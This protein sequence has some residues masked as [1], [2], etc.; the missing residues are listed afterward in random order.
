VESAKDW[1]VEGVWNGPFTAAGMLDATMLLGSGGHATKDRV[2]FAATSHS[3]D[4]LQYTRVGDDLLISNSLAFLFAQADDG[5]DPAY[6]FY[7]QDLISFVDGLSHAVRRIPTL[8]GSVHLAYSSNLVVD[9]DLHILE[10]R[11]RL[12]RSFADYA[13]YVSFL[14]RELASIHRNATAPERARSGYQP[15]A[16]ISSGYDSPA[17]AVLAQCIGAREAVT[18]R[19]AREDYGGQADSGALVGG[20]LGLS[21]AEYDRSHYIRNDQ[22][23]EAEFLGVGTGGEDIVMSAFEPHLPGRLL[24][25]GFLGDRLW[26]RLYR[27]DPNEAADFPMK[28]PAGSSLTEFRLRVGFVHVPV[29]LLTLGAHPSLYVISNSAAMRAWRVG[30]PRYDR[31][32]PRRLVEDAGVPRHLFGQAKRAVTQP[33]YH[34]E[35][36]RDIMSPRSFRDFE[37]FA[38]PRADLHHAGGRSVALA[39]L[40]PIHAVQHFVDRALSSAA[41]RLGVSLSMGPAVPRR[42]R[43]RLTMNALTFHWAQEKL[44]PRYSTPVELRGP[45]ARSAGTAGPRT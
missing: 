45:V 18:F 42:Y 20:I 19:A 14:Q 38:G 29:P 41:D 23:Q 5:P 4:R 28:F 30:N 16:T 24:F 44:R 27:P 2:T 43:Q 36:L 25:T 10:R 12:P 8:R 9:A 31:P 17:C 21:V 22:L 13:D 32:I 40:P 33:F 34:N 7:D 39:V 6:L 26:S 15:L 37:E 1:F 3:M 35:R 11:R